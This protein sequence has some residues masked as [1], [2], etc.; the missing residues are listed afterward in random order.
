MV[1][2][3]IRKKFYKAC[4]VIHDHS[5]RIISERKELIKKEKKGSR[6]T[7]FLDILITAKVFIINSIMLHNCLSYEAFQ[8]NML[9]GYWE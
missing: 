7:D 5:S 1:C 8:R 9:T 3:F 4:D 6:N 2:L